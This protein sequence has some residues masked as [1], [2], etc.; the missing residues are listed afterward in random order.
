[1]TLVNKA[2]STAIVIASN[3]FNRAS[4]VG[5]RASGAGFLRAARHSRDLGLSRRG[6]PAEEKTEASRGKARERRGGMRAAQGATQPQ[7]H[8]SQNQRLMHYTYWG[9]LQ[10]RRQKWR[11][12]VPAATGA[13][14]SSGQAGVDSF[15]LARVLRSV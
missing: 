2:S 9:N 4:G 11:W 3:L 1:M 14:S 8:A 6:R 15:W 13:P 5:R 12:R 10:G 7:G